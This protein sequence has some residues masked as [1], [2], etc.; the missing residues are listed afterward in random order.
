MNILNRGQIVV[1]PTKKFEEWATKNSEETL[2]FSESPEPTVYLIEEEFWDDELIIEKYRKKILR[3]EFSE[4]CMDETTWPIL[5]DN[6]S[7]L[8]YFDLHLG[9][10]VID[11]LDTDLISEE[12]DL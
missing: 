5:K 11:L 12:V 9:I 3:R 4:I 1:F 6:E 7:F 2:Y 8:T 10:M